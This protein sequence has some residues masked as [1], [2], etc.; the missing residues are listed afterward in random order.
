MT[1]RVL[2]VLILATLV[3]L[4][5]CSWADGPSPLSFHQVAD[6]DSQETITLPLAENT[7]ETLILEKKPLLDSS[8]VKSVY[9]FMREQLVNGVKQ[10][11]WVITVKFTTA[12]TQKV[13]QVTES[14]V[15]KKLAVVVHGKVLSAPYVHEAITGGSAE[16]SGNFSEAEATRIASLIT[17]DR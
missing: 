15:G 5:Q 7:T 6:P 1:S 13:A 10:T 2:P 16:I 8:D 17:N 14:L 4:V 11:I 9:P 12:G 3:G